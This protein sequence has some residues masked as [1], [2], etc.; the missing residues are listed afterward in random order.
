ML[1]RTEMAK[2]IRPEETTEETLVRAESARSVLESE[3]F[4]ESVL[5]VRENI[6]KRW[7]VAET[8]QK[9]E[10]AHSL[11]WSLREVL[12]QLKIVMERG[13]I[14]EVQAEES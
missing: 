3:L 6:I 7:E 10:E 11:L 4:V 8:T 9:R 13:E 12:K 1:G 5:T 14:L 2:E